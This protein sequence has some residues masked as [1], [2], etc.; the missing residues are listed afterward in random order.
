MQAIK[1]ITSRFSA[2]TKPSMRCFSVSWSELHMAENKLKRKLNAMKMMTEDAEFTYEPPNM[3]YD[4]STGDVQI[5]QKEI[6]KKPTIITSFNDMEREKA[7]LFKEMGVEDG[8]LEKHDVAGNLEET[9]D[10]IYKIENRIDM[11]WDFDPS[12]F[13]VFSRDY[14]RIDCGLII[15]RPPIFLHMRDPDIELMKMRS[16]VMNEYFCD[17]KKYVKEYAEVTQ[18]NES[19]FAENPYVS[20]MNL[21][22]YPTHEM[23]DPVTGETSKYCAASK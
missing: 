20:D 1:P 22:N 18:L 21:D 8:D 15:M 12:K 14:F 7:A 10:I 13:N 11:E 2:L 3:I 4:K 6:V 16:T 17:F 5:L 23:T 19:I 9:A